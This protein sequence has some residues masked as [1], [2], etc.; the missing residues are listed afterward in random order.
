[1]M[2]NYDKEYPGYFLG[3]HKGYGT[4]QHMAKIIS[5]G[6]LPIHRRSFAPIKKRL[7]YLV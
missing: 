1:M 3:Q 6:V 7:K 5:Y 4:A 2:E